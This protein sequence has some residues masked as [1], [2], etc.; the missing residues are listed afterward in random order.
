M[1][2]KRLS[3]TIQQHTKRV[4]YHEQVEFITVIEGWLNIQNSKSKSHDYIN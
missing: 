1:L 2:N 4:I 3:N